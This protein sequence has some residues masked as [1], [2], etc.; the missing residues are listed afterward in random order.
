M[1]DMM[2]GKVI[3]R[4]MRPTITVV[5]TWINVKTFDGINAAKVPPKMIAAEMTTVPIIVAE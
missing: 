1:A 4:M 5:A 2:I 3:A